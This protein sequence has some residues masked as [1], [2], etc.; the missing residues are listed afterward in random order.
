MGIGNKLMNKAE[1]IIKEQS[2]FAGIGVGLFSD[3]GPA[4][5]MYIKRGYVPDGKG[6]YKK[7]S[8]IKFGE[9][10][11]I[12]DDVVLYFIKELK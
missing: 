3:Y 8:Y 9:T 6:I 1:E 10:I 7:D 4:Q 5:I 12:D 2:D 11:I